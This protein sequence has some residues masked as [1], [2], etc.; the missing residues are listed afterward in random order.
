MYGAHVHNLSM[1]CL[2]LAQTF[3]HTESNLVNKST[4]HFA[5]I[6]KSIALLNLQDWPCFQ[7]SEAEKQPSCEQNWIHT[8]SMRY[9]VNREVVMTLNLITVN[10]D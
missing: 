10:T 2:G 4:Y 6:Q 3:L 1:S 8:L 9:K 7:H 5:Q